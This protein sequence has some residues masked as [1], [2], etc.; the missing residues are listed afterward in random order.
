M[1]KDNIEKQQKNFKNDVFV[2]GMICLEMASLKSCDNIYDYTE[3]RIDSEKLENLLT[4]VGKQYSEELIS[5]LRL[6]L[7][8]DENQRLSFSQLNT[9]LKKIKKNNSNPVIF[10]FLKLS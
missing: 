8:I 2:L 4:F 3:Y 9:Q 10:I 7:N 1:E 6:M 5:F